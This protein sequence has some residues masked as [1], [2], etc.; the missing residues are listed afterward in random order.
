[1]DGLFRKY[2]GDEYNEIFRKIR[3]QASQDR[4]EALKALWAG[5]WFSASP[6]ER[7]SNRFFQ[8][9]TKHRQLRAKVE[10]CN[11]HS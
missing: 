10:A 3:R 9:L 6:I 11:A 4:T 7:A 2:T 8:A 1:M 5:A